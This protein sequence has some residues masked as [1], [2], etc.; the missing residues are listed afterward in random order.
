[1]AAKSSL[2][3]VTDEDKELLFKYVIQLY[4]QDTG[5]SLIAKY[6]NNLW[7][8]DGLAYC[9][10][11]ESLSFFCEYFLQDT[12]R[13]KEGNT[14]R[15][16]APFHFELWDTLQNMFIEDSFD[17]LE[18]V[19]PRASSKSTT[20]DFGLSVWLHCYGVSKYTIIAGKTDN[21]AVGFVR[22]IRRA[23]EENPYII[24]A[25]GKL[26]N[27]KKYVTNANELELANG[28]KLEALSSKSSIRGRLFLS[29]RPSCI[30]ADDYQAK[31]DVLTQEARDK[32]YATWVEDVA[33]A[34]D[35]PTIRNGKKIKM[36]TKFVVLGTILHPD[37]LMSRLLKDNT[38]KHI[39][40]RAI[41]M[42]DIDTYFNSGL[43]GDLKKI[44]FNPKDPIALD[45]AK[46]F[47]YQ[48]KAEMQ[49][50]VLW[51]DKY[52]CGDL[53]INDYFP[54]PQSFRQEMQND[55][56]KVGERAFHMLKTMPAE[57]IEANTFNL[58]VLACDPAVETGAKNDFTALAVAGKTDNNFQWIRKGIIERLSFD[59]YIDKITNLLEDY[60]DISY[61]WIEKNTYSGADAR[62]IRQKIAEHDTLKHRHI[63]IINE[64]QKAN[65]ENKI[66]ALSGKVDSGFIIFNEEDTAFNE[67]VLNYEGEIYSSHD[68]SPDCLSEASRLL[69]TLNIAVPKVQLF[70]T[71]FLGL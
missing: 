71:S 65:K 26:I 24:G 14:A 23:F 42:D 13:P 25:F 67:Q 43:W 31:D 27:S 9:I 2:P 18:L 66:R 45:N 58:T 10:G 29:A 16:L 54:N 33:L 51:Q 8:H 61:I 12:F 38:Y 3:P 17:K 20:C 19:M 53:A 55:V 46:E 56:T 4:G 50:P 5:E 35:K 21:D 48:H 37:C 11:R 28:T 69:E 7:G 40:K 68:D 1:M 41:E 39:V 34:G 30:I 15:K 62:A 60:E 52:D 44:M 64:Y 49:Y 63:E 6:E 36:G 32:K 70:K 59:Q 22:N 57:E 47:Y